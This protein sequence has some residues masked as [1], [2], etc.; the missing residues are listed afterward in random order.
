MAARSCCRNQSPK[1]HVC[2][3]QRLVGAHWATGA[4]GAAG[5]GQGLGGGEEEPPTSAHS[6]NDGLAKGI[7][8]EVDVERARTLDGW[9]VSAGS[10]PPVTGVVLAVPTRQGVRGGVL[11]KAQKGEGSGRSHTIRRHAR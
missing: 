4:A 9:R 2:F 10:G 8:D 1:R 6:L 11:G 7:G 3:R 5:A